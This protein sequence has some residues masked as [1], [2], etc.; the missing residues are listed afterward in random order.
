VDELTEWRENLGQGGIGSQ[1]VLVA[2]PPGWGRSTVLDEFAAVVGGD[3][4][5]AT[6]VVRITGGLPP[7]RAVQ[8]EA[9]R[10]DLTSPGLE[11]RIVSLLGL[12]T[13]AGQAQLALGVGGL[14]TSGLAAAA[15]LL[16]ASLAAKIA[17]NAWDASPAG[18]AGGV[19]RAA[20]D[21]ARVSVSVPVVVIIDDADCLDLSLA[22]ALIRGLTGRVDGQVLAVAAAAPDSG[23]VRALAKDPGYEL[24]GR[25]HR[26]EA[27]PSMGYAARRELAAA[28]L[29]DLPATGAE[30]VARRTVTFGEV[31]AVAGA[32]QLAELAPQAETVEV[33][34]V[35]DA[36][37]DAVLE[38]VRPSAEAVALAWAG[39]ALHARQ[40]ERAVQVLGGG[41]HDDDRRVMRTGSLTRL[42][43]PPDGQVTVQIAALPRADRQRLA[44]VVLAEAGALAADAD[45]GLVERVVARQAAHHV[46]GDLADR[47][48]LVGVQLGLIRGLESLGDPAAA[49]DV[50]ATALAET[51]TWPSAAL[52]A[53]QRQELMMA[54]LRL[55]RTGGGQH[56]DPVAAEAVELALAGGAAVRAEARVWA[57]VDLLHRP[58]RR[59]DGLEQA[60]RVTKELEDRRI[61]GEVASQWRLLL[62]FHVGQAEDLAL[63]QRLLATLVSTGSADQQDA[64]AA[65]LRAIDGPRADT[66]LQI[67]LL[68]AEFARTPADRD[69]ELLRLYHAL[70][71]DYHTLGDYRQA[72]HAARRELPLRRRIQGDD[73]PDTLATRCNIAI[74]TGQ[75]GD[76]AGALRLFL[77][78]LPDQVRVLGPR[79][80]ATL[81]TRAGIAFQTGE[82][83]D[84]AAALWTFQELLPDMVSA[85]G[86]GHPETLIARSNTAFWAGRSGDVAA[87]L[88]LCQELLPDQVRV[89][90]RADPD[91][92]ATR[93]GIAFWT[94]E[95]GQATA[96]LRLFR[97]LL[98]DL[99]RVLGHDHPR[100]LT[101]RGN[102][103]RWTGE[104][105]DVAAALRL[106]QELLPDQVRVLGPDHPDTLAARR[107]IAIWSGKYGDAAAALRL[108]QELLPDQIRVLGP[109]HPDTL[110]VR[111]GIASWTGQSG[112][113]AGALRLFQELLPDQVRVLGPDHRDTLATRAIIAVL[114]GQSTDPAVALRLLQELLADVARVQGTDHPNTL[115]TRA[116]IAYWTGQSGDPAEALRLL[117][118]L[119]PDQVR[120]LGPDH[121]DTIMTKG[122]I[123]AGQAAHT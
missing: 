6:L 110:T 62:A 106:L 15:S 45:A 61:H 70:A 92:L 121:P 100:T 5:P 91:T 74:W 7:G 120:V 49:Y 107:G 102:I 86:A 123:A 24:A 22:L 50:A 34:R 30:R 26:V 3:K 117:R 28:L 105:G 112:D 19:A 17:G 118:E 114:T 111:A 1:V 31:F 52:D 11:S 89:L 36:V 55:A 75:S 71:L 2:V 8:A 98:P 54:A 18:E 99:V 93:N 10:R 47:T 56:D 88:R 51:D 4:G 33:L 14:F 23:L 76:A 59:Q 27:D 67:I 78:L 68:R 60:R 115:A 44:A 12:D 57:A 119:L 38:W 58:G 85:L 63:A 53:G 83:G 69:A 101:V 37:A 39:G 87:A 13:T 113:A 103:A 32:G 116:G 84:A 94:G 79:R 43:G 46:R 9:L 81:A 64:A 82:C 109:D 77:E 73:H 97:E 29:P 35:V 25:V 40:A 72:L 80:Q 65:V 96:A 20:R 90:G 48:G 41:R 122:R 42:S 21:L 16:V 104:C 108:F 95:C 66:R